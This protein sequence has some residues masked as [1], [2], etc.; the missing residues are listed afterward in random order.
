LAVGVVVLLRA[1]A[2][3]YF[4][5]VLVAAARAKINPLVVFICL[6]ALI[7]LLSASLL[8]CFLLTYMAERV[9]EPAPPGLRVAAVTTFVSGGEPVLML[10]NTLRA[11]LDLAY[12][13]DTWVLD[14]SDDP[15]VRELCTKLGVLH[16]TRKHLL[17]Y[18]SPGGKFESACKH[19]NYNAWLYS[20][21]FARYDIIAAF[22]PD[23]LPAPG[24]LDAALGCFND[25][26][27]GY[28]Q[29][30]QAYYNQDASFIARGASEETQTFYSVVQRA[31]QWF[32]CPAIIGCHN[33]HRVTALRQAGGFAPHAADD[34]L[35][36]LVYQSLGWKG[37]YISRL[38]AKGLTPVDWQGYLTQQR[39]WA[40]SLLDVKLRVLPKLTRD[41]PP[42]RRILAFLQGVTY[43]QD[44]VAALGLLLVL[45]IVLATGLGASVFSALHRFD[46]AIVVGIYLMTDLFS[47]RFYLDR[48]AGIG[49]HWRAAILRAAKWP[50][51]LLAVVEVVSNHQFPYALTVKTGSASRKVIFWPHLVIAGVV[52]AAWAAGALA[53]RPQD[54]LVHVG[55]S[56]VIS[57]CLLIFLSGFWRFPAPYDPDLQKRSWSM[58][59][60]CPAT[61]A[62]PHESNQVNS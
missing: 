25:P 46:L 35:L 52:G 34:L 16:F 41:W 47:H 24:F 22:D 55:A 6:A 14:E 13:H 29:F 42:R 62:A 11:M 36:G 26:R 43:L 32:G 27:I 45:M 2:V 37:V 61:A 50:Y 21:G 19:G 49:F 9:H 8:R 1:A 15:E 54:S 12:P 5:A 20:T 59:S 53:H 23:H 40:R 44:V 38:L 30:P 7:V 18:H 3:V 48:S 31:N 56:V 58:Q 33:T 4:C 10:E 28:V 60:D 51:T 17:Q 57:I 39:R